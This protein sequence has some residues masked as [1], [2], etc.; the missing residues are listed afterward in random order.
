MPSIRQSFQTGNIERTA[1]LRSKHV[2]S[3]ILASYFWKC[4]FFSSDRRKNNK[5][6]AK[7]YFLGTVKDNISWDITKVEDLY[8]FFALLDVFVWHSIG[9]LCPLIQFWIALK[10]LQLHAYTFCFSPNFSLPEIAINCYIHP[11]VWANRFLKSCFG[12][13]NKIVIP[14]VLWSSLS[15]D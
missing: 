3:L 8:V 7:Q 1:P 12:R 5:S 13:S 6:Q 4:L 9:Q 14:Q 2:L 10:L 11:L 15:T